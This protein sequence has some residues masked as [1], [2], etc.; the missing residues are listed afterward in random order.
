MR[1]SSQFLLK[2]FNIQSTLIYNNSFIA[3]GYNK[4]RQHAIQT[5]IKI[6]EERAKQYM[7]NLSKDLDI[8][9][10]IQGFNGFVGN[11]L[12]GE[13]KQEIVEFLTCH[14]GLYFVKIEYV[15]SVVPL[16][17]NQLVNLS[18]SVSR[19]ISLNEFFDKEKTEVDESQNLENDPHLTWVID[20][21][22]RPFNERDFYKM[23]IGAIQIHSVKKVIFQNKK[24]VDNP[25]ST[26]IKYVVFNSKDYLANIL[27]RY[28]EGCEY[29]NES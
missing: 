20:S 6:Y 22:E 28:Y 19:S 24:K 21:S 7:V 26:L 23:V 10:C 9:Q 12:H 17:S 11:Y 8:N 13:I 14:D 18:N 1:I 27:I 16:V 29:F 25:K 3:W 5:Q 15:T 4:I 2:I